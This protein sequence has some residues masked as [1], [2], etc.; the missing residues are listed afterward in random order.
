[1]D[2]FF[3]IAEV[4]AVY[5]SKGFVLI[6][7]YSDFS[8]RFFKL[9]S[10]YLEF[11]S[12][13]KE[14]FVENVMEVGGNFA[15]KFKGFDN[16]EDVKFLLGK[17]IYVDKEHSVKLSADTYF[18]HDLIGSEVFQGSK[19][20]GLLEDVLILHSNDVYVIRDAD[21]KK[22]LIP[23]IKDYVQSF[24]PVKKRLELI[25]DCDLLYDDEN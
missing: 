7:S 24:D 9:N 11:F 8:E 17:K 14:F 13:R 18:I 25:P 23:A 3:L 6:E 1:M 12:S 20:I 16:N 15:L 5:G 22:I 19:L 10:V 21:K 2:D 4:K